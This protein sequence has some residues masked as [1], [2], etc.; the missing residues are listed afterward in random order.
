MFELMD[1]QPSRREGAGKVQVP[2]SAT[3]P[4]AFDDHRLWAVKGDHKWLR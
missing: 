1:Q 4:R 3:G 2:G